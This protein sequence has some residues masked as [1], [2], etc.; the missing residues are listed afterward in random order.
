M[1]REDFQLVAF[2]TDTEHRSLHRQLAES[3]L[4]LQQAQHLL[5]AQHKEI[6]RLRLE[7]RTGPETGALTRRGLQ[8]ALEAYGPHRPACV[9]ALDLRG[10]RDVDRR[11]GRAV[12][13]T[14]LRAVLTQMERCLRHDDAVARTG[15]D[16]FTMV[17][18]DAIL[19]DGLAVAQRVRDQ[20]RRL[21]FRH[22]GRH[23][24]VRVCIGVAERTI[25]ERWAPV[26]ERADAALWA[27]RRRG[28]DQIVHL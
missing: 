28:H 20:V 10:F 17:L 19:E 6:E 8:D 13:C 25:V 1:A 4:A 9:L 26:F 27:A 12:S 7:R 5:A 21:R 18:P 15:E 22:H 24:G 3:H 16:S 23:F 11:V 14:V 2:A